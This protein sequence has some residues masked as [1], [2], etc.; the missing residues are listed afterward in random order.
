MKEREIDTGEY[1]NS[2]GI[3]SAYNSNMMQ[4][5]ILTLHSITS[6]RTIG[7]NRCN[8]RICALLP[9]WHRQCSARSRSFLFC[10]PPSPAAS[11]AGR[12]RLGF[13][14]HGSPDAVPEVDK[15]ATDGTYKILVGNKCDAQEER[16]VRWLVDSSER[17]DPK[18]RLAIYN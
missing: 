6:L 4:Y 7:R 13:A 8:H 9:L 16:Q 17:N 18:F 5:V 12:A 14:R 3:N 10:F 1:I 2:V 15:Y 11:C